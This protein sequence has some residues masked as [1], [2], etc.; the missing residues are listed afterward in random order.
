MAPP[1]CRA[2]PFDGRPTV[3]GAAAE[4]RLDGTDLGVGRRSRFYWRTTSKLLMAFGEF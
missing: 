3:F 4:R 1:Y 2:T